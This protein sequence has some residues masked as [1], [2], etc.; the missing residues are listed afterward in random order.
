MVALVAMEQLQDLTAEHIRQ[1]KFKVLNACRPV[2][3]DDVVTGQYAGY[4][5]DEGIA[6]KHVA[7]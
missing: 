5:D 4:R 7:S 1:E 2:T 6:D 3:L